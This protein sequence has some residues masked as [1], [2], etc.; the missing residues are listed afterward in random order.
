MRVD[1]FVRSTQDG[2]PCLRV[3]ASKPIGG[4]RFELFEF[5]VGLELRVTTR[6]VARA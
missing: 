2:K 5:E 6:E 4:G 3:L 1:G